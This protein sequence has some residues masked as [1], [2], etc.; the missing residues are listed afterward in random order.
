MSNEEKLPM[1]LNVTYDKTQVSDEAVENLPAAL[2]G[3]GEGTGY[4]GP[5][6]VVLQEKKEYV[7]SVLL[8]I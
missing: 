7:P 8:G 5:Y 1:A 6:A 4:T 3:C 2:L